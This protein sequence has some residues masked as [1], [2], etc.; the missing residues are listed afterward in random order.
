MNDNKFKR[1]LKFIDA[2]EKELRDKVEFLRRSAN[3][4]T[5]WTAVF[6]ALFGSWFLLL[7]YN[8][9]LAEQLRNYLIG[10][11]IYCIY[12]A[13]KKVKLPK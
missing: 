9:E 7:Q 13:V 6:I 4:L 10:A 12:R 5:I 3:R 11:L 1:E 8:P 2:R